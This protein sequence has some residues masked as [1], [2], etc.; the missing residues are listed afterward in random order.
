MTHHRFFPLLS[1]AALLLA[2]FALWAGNLGHAELTEEEAFVDILASKSLGEIVQ[3]LNTDE[4]HP[5][6]YYLMTHAW[7]LLGGTRNE[8]L[9]RFPS[10]T[11]GLLLL[12]LTYRLGRTSGLSW[13]PAL[14]AMAWL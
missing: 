10:I 12:S 9:V 8:F 1:C 7:N 13:G 6:L 3:Q 5:P 11:L 2:F 14:I 4:P